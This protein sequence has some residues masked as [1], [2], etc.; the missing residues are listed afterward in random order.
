M[1]NILSL[2]A[3]LVLILSCSNDPGS[4]GDLLL[5]GKVSFDNPKAFFIHSS[6]ENEY[7]SEL[8]YIDQ[9]NQPQRV[10]Y[11]DEAGNQLDSLPQSN[12]YGTEAEGV[13]LYPL[14][15]D[16]FILKVGWDYYLVDKQDGSAHFIQSFLDLFEKGISNSYR[17]FENLDRYHM[18]SADNFYFRGDNI[19]RL[20]IDN[21]SDIS[22]KQLSPSMD[23]VYKSTV[24]DDGLIMYDSPSVSKLIHQDGYLIYM[25]NSYSYMW[26][27]TEGDIQYFDSD[28]DRIVTIIQDESQ[29]I[30]YTNAAFS[31]FLNLDTVFHT[32]SYTILITQNDDII[33]VFYDGSSTLL[34]L[35]LN[36]SINC[37]EAG[38]QYV[39]ISLTLED[40]SSSF[41]R[42]RPST[43]S[44][45][46]L[47]NA[48]EYKIMNL[49]LM[50]GGGLLFKGIRNS[51]DEIVTG[52]I[53]E[54]GSV[55]LFTLSY[56]DYAYRFLGVNNGDEF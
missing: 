42:L 26:K 9:D 6:P 3:V 22:V 16:Y 7:E 40:G 55:E 56:P 28:N 1:K 47:S 54:D 39:Y 45:I 2:L 37:V 33:R 49:K 5:I 24:S 17:D 27:N 48:D 21:L 20:N 13:Y 12:N 10:I 31:S 14:S 23:S 41:I 19:S 32:Q 25:E 46:T 18:N 38:T 52:T 35:P 44:F 50:D 29:N 51:D 4:T 36:S 11:Y 34:T 53:N 15:E 43:D 30:S 8:N